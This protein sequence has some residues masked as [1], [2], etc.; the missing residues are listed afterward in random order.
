MANWKKVIVSG[1]TANLASLQVD[2]LTSGQ[3]VIGGGASL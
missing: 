1:S 3:V 2:D